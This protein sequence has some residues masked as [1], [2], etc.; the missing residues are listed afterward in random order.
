MG[1]E[2]EVAEKVGVMTKSV[3]PRS[4]NREDDDQ[5]YCTETPLGECRVA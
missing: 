3:C 4:K 2:V 1:K 5:L